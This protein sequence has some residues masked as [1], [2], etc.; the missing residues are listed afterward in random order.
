MFLAW[1]YA[2][3]SFLWI[4]VGA[5]LLVSLTIL[6][7]GSPFRSK[8]PKTSEEVLSLIGKSVDSLRENI[9]DRDGVS[10]RIE[11]EL[12]ILEDIEK[13]E[14]E[15]DDLP[16]SMRMKA[17]AVVFAYVLYSLF[18][19]IIGVSISMV[20]NPY[21]YVISSEGPLDKAGS[22]EAQSIIADNLFELSLGIAI[23]FSGLFSLYGFVID[24][25]KWFRDSC[26]VT[27]AL[28]LPVAI[29]NIDPVQ[30]DF[31]GF[32][33][34]PLLFSGD[35]K[36]LWKWILSNERVKQLMEKGESLGIDPRLLFFIGVIALAFGIIPA[37]FIIVFILVYKKWDNEDGTQFE[38]WVGNILKLLRKKWMTINTYTGIRSL[39][40]ILAFLSVILFLAVFIFQFF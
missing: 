19:S 32:V 4:L 12:D 39:L 14:T 1:N 9:L 18:V 29:F 8:K 21:F 11:G 13:E 10:G 25:K 35:L 15:Q 33:I 36:Q 2:L 27:A 7:A 40:Y 16:L 3:E 38:R 6:L 34:I 23:F 26:R 24:N 37:A 28:F 31:I 22:E 17:Y 30:D 5:I 20:I